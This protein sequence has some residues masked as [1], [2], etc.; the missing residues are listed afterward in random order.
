MF[1]FDIFGGP[2]LAQHNPQIRKRVVNVDYKM[3]K[4]MRK[5]HVALI[6]SML[7]LEPLD[8]PSIAQLATVRVRI[9]FCCCWWG[10]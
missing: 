3:D 8:R 6:K 2:T 7:Q 1:I 9:L 5:E 4:G 10:W